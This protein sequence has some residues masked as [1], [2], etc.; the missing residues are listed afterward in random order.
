MKRREVL[1]AMGTMALA[2]CATEGISADGNTNGVRQQLTPGKRRK[3]N[4][5]TKVT[6]SQY[7]FRDQATRLMETIARQGNEVVFGDKRVTSDLLQGEALRYFTRVFAAGLI[8]Q[9]EGNDPA[10]PNFIKILS[11]WL[12]WG[13]PNPDGTYSFANLHGD[14]TYRLY[15]KRGQ[16]RLFDIEVWEGDIADLGS[17]VS[18]GGRRSIYGGKSDLQID[19]DGSFEVIL[20]AEEQ[21]GNWIRLPRGHAHLYVRQWYYDY[22]NE[23][24][25]Q[26]YIERVGAQFPR[27]ALTAKNHAEN[28]ERLIQ[29]VNTVFTPLNKGIA[30]HY[31]SEP[32]IVPFPAGLISSGNAF[33]NQSYGRGRFTCQPDEAV[34][35]EVTRPQAEYWMFGLLSPF[36]ESYDW[37]GRQISINGYQAVIDDDGKFRAVISHQDPGVPNW[38]DASGHTQGL[39]AARYN[40]SETVPIPTLRTVPFA[41][42]AEALPSTTRRIS[43]TERHEILRRRNLSQRRRMVDW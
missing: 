27:P 12:N 16:A 40:W 30:M 23:M 3:A 11:P 20:S 14:H 15:G 29:F 25:G 32:N 10:Y 17:A 28:F 2:A 37:L 26:F 19:A 35:L 21:K 31:A 1:R 7:D 34:I 4:N 41:S 5:E 22:E 42:L 38:L 33:R 39:I 36:W 24:S 18:I 6:N 9:V 13:Y 43:P 8:S